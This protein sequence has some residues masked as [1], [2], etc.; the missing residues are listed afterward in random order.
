MSGSLCAHT[1]DWAQEQFGGVD[2]GDAR[3]DGRTLRIAA[4]MAAAPDRSLPDQHGSWADIKA[5]YRFFQMS[6]GLLHYFKSNE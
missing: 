4:A 2:L 3:L 5:A 1:A 6:S